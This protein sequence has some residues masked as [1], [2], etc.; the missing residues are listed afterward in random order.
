MPTKG[1]KKCGNAGCESKF[2]ETDSAIQCSVCKK[3]F[4]F[5]CIFPSLK[6]DSNDDIAFA[7]RSLCQTNCMVT[8]QACLFGNSL[9]LSV[10][11]SLQEVRAKM[12]SIEKSV[13]E[14]KEKSSSESH[15]EEDLF[16]DCASSLGEFKVVE[17]RKKRK[18]N[19]DNPILRLVEETKK[20]LKVRADAE[21]KRSAVI[22][23]LPDDNHGQTSFHLLDSI[24]QMSASVQIPPTNICDVKRM[25]FKKSKD[26][27]RPVK[28]IF[29]NSV[30]AAEFI[31]RHRD[32]NLGNTWVRPS[33]SNEERAFIRQAKE[34]NRNQDPHR[35]GKSFAMRNGKLVC[36]IRRKN[37][38][39]SIFWAK[40]RNWKHE[41]EEEEG[42]KTPGTR[43]WGDSL[44]SHPNAPQGNPNTTKKLSNAS[45]V[46]NLSSN[47]QRPSEN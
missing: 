40:D 18:M 12:D 22:V 2:I 9:V 5:P 35:S 28:V 42:G 17:G 21:R 30:A 8:C 34:M 41:E 6:I 19:R 15:Q 4:D 25:G 38:D 33:Y 1:T 20:E 16:D 7:I 43:P 37:K 47:S 26:W 13:Q 39:G 24:H 46:S 27:M 44:F 23:K 45:Q 10:A 32:R 36:F 29:V 3:L 14:I 31:N 11:E